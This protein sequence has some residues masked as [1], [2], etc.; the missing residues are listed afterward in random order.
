LPTTDLPKKRPGRRKNIPK[1]LI[2]DD[3]SANLYLLE[4][5]LKGHGLAVTNARNGRDALDKARLN[6]PDL[7]V[8]DILMPVM[9]GYALCRELKADGRLR[10]IPLIFYTA[11]YTETKDEAFALSLGA[12]RFIIK[13]QEPDIL[14]NLITAV[15]KEKRRTKKAVVKPLGEEMECFRQYNEI[16]FKKLEKKMIDLEAANQKLRTLE[17]RYRMSFGHIRDVVYTIDTDLN[18][19]DMSPSV[20]KILGYKPQ[21]LIGRPIP[22]LNHIIAPESLSQAIDD[23]RRVL[24][25]ENIPVAQYR[26]VARDGTQKIGEVV[27]SPVKRDGRV[28]GMI[29]VARDITAH[30]QSE[31]RVRE[32]EKRY[33]E[34]YDFLPI[35]VYEM[36]LEGNITSFNRAIHEV[37]GSTEEDLKK[38]IQVWQIISPEDRDRYQENLE[39]LLQGEKT[40]SIEFILRRLDGSLFPAIIVSSVIYSNGISA[41]FR[42]AV[43]DITERKWMED[44]LRQ[45]NAFL[46]SIIENIPDVIFLKDAKELRYVRFNRAGEVLI[47]QSRDNL[48]GKNDYDFFPKDQADFFT[49]KDREVLQ[50]KELVDIPEEHIQTTDKGER[51]LHTKKLSILNMKGEPEY[52][53][54]ISE[55]IT[56]RKRAEAALRE[57]EIKFKDLSEKSIAGIYLIQDGRYRYVNSTFAEILGYKIDEM[58]DIMG[59]EDVVFH[60]DWPLVE[61]NVQKRLSGAV[62]SVHYDFRIMTKQGIVRHMEVHSSATIYKGR[63]AAIGTM[64]DITDRKRAEEQLKESEERYKSVFE[65]H[66]AIKFLI[67]P[68]TGRI[69]EANKAAVKYYGWTHEELMQMKI[70]E[71]NALSSEEV[72]QEMGKALTKEKT[73]FEFRHRLADGSTRD[74]EVYSSTIDIK[75][76]KLLHA[77]VHDISERKRSQELYETLAL[78]SLAAVFI[79]QDGKFRF[80][81]KS[82]IAYMGYTEED[83]LGRD[84]DIIIYPE[85]KTMAN[86][87]AKEMLSGARATAYEYR[88]VTKQNQIRWISQMV[89][90]IIYDGRPAILGNALDVTDLKE[91][92]NR[93]EEM[94]ALESS[95]MSAI[96][97]VVIGSQDGLILFVNDAA[98]VAF[99]WK[100]EELIGREIRTLCRDENEFLKLVRSLDI[101][102]DNGLPGRQE[103]EIHCI[104]R[105][106]G[107]IVCKVT[108]S[109]IV[110]A[111]GQK[112]VSI[113]EDITAKKMSHI[114]L[115][116]S[117]KMASI[118][119]LAAGVAHEINNPTA[120]V[121]SNLKT[122]SEYIVDMI[123]VKNKYRAMLDALKTLR[124]GDPLPDTI[125]DLILQ[126]EDLEEKLKIGMVFDDVVALIAESREGTG[127]ISR[128]VQDLKNFAHPGEEK[129]TTFN[130][131]ENIESTLSIVWNEL[132]Y[133][134]VVYKDYGDIPQ[135]LGYPQ[136]LNQVFLNLFINAVQA[137]KEKGEIRISTREVDGHIEIKIADT[138]VGIPPENLPKLFDPFFTTKEVG[139]GTGL[140]L[141][142]AYSIIE[143]HNGNIDVESTI[144]VGTTFIVRI[145]IQTN[146]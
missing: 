119:K 19:I 6:P 51:I 124:P 109:R 80:I 77:I 43:I 2:V 44:K 22:E 103:A 14:L 54:G 34:L 91:S 108:S 26:F 100:P 89:V 42:S 62:K 112:I 146:G 129:R 92:R 98:E 73:Y 30:R 75:G 102:N 50:R 74:V 123:A 127:R 15:L 66:S 140:G 3:N 97:H 125:K 117:E 13:P 83:I 87:M 61:R 21:D 78:S 17:D 121:S 132:K 57:S 23:I 84:S 35:P 135:M 90:P 28:I 60:E 81:N 144:G 12:D 68:D 47:G 104:R 70:Q 93:L 82:A 41:G 95:I 55:D 88:I 40:R 96:P 53:L 25:G 138:G 49:E 8:T 133:K 126:T 33:R 106:R 4:T 111:A 9:D 143:K 145:P 11:T 39:R 79:V 71:I 64:L 114:Q 31:E 24:N 134:A 7:I 58:I 139:K 48:L 67:D 107:S 56:E 122:L 63:P 131:N 1:I 5:L 18:L 136:Q 29:S 38:G 20:E 113:F 27:G 99:G 32:S 116:Q 52:L 110:G 142:V 59:P 36:D 94:K 72:E 37:F 65:N 128:I 118:G 101:E 85:D 10:H 115:L 86:D 45:T 76:K 137:I 69:V 141:H 46:D 120:F 130:V 16:L 105:N